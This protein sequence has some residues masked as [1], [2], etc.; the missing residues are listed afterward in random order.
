MLLHQVLVEDAPSPRK[1]NGSVPKDLETIC[2]KCL[3][4]D[5][6]R[7]YQT[8]RQ[9]G[10][11]LQRFHSGEPV[12]ARPISRAERVWRWCRRKPGMAAALASIAALLVLVTLISSVA[13]VYLR[14]QERKQRRLADSNRELAEQAQSAERQAEDESERN[15]RLLYTSDM[16]LAL[17]AWE[18]A[19][20]NRCLELLD[21]H[22]PPPGKEDLRGFEWNYVAQLCQRSQHATTLDCSTDVFGVAF[23]PDDKTLATAHNNTLSLWQLNSTDPPVGLPAPWNGATSVSYSPDGKLLA[24]GNGRGT[25]AIWDVQGERQLHTLK[26]NSTMCSAVA[27][28]PDGN[29]LASANRGRGPDNV[30]L[31]DVTTGQLLVTL[32]SHTSPVSD[33]MDVAF[34]PD[35]KV[36]ASAGY[37]ATLRVWDA[38]THEE[39][40]VLDGHNERV[41][42]VAF[43]PDGKVLASGGSDQNIRLWDTSTWQ[44]VALLAGHNQTVTSVQFS[45]DGETLASG[46]FDRE[47]KLWNLNTNK[48]R[49]TL[50]GHSSVVSSLA[51][52]HD[53]TTLASASH[54][55]TVKIWD[56]APDK[57]VHL[58]EGT[59]A[60]G[61]ALS[62]YADVSADGS[63]I[64]SE[65]FGNQIRVHDVTTGK[66]W[67]LP[68]EGRLNVAISRGGKLLALA[69]GTDNTIRVRDVPTGAIVHT[70]ANPADTFPLSF[71]G[72]GKLLAAGC[73]DG[74]IT[75]WNMET[76]ERRATLKGSQAVPVR[77]FAFSP[78]DRLLASVHSD[79]QIKLRNIATGQLRAKLWGAAFNLTFSPDGRTLVSFGKEIFVSN[80]ATGQRIELLEGHAG[81]VTSLAFS[82]NGKWLAS[83]SEDRNVILWDTTNWEQRFVFKG[84]EHGVQ[85]VAFTPDG[86]CLA[87]AEGTGTIRLWRATTDADF[88]RKAI[89]RTNLV[90]RAYYRGVKGEY[91]QAADDARRAEQLSPEGSSTR[92]EAAYYLAFLLLQL[93]KVQEY[94]Q[95]CLRTLQDFQD[96]ENVFIACQTAALC[97][98]HPWHGLGHERAAELADVAA[99]NIKTAIA[100]GSASSDLVPLVQLVKGICDYRRGQFAAAID[101]LERDELSEI[102]VPHFKALRLLFLAMAYHH[103]GQP[104][105]ARRLFQHAAEMIGELPTQG[106]GWQYVTFCRIARH[107]SEK[108]IG[109]ECEDNRPNETVSPKEID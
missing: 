7:R 105:P 22:R 55:G 50:K 101:W 37:D 54:D 94:D 92:N 20:L 70:L 60:P 40:V 107:E 33:V 26:V 30:K 31:W 59:A 21:R 89:T 88:Q 85:A 66:E 48:E 13:A 84:H 5:P 81:Y 82:P 6:H 77:D 75:L 56:V 90:A 24:V 44:E 103:D 39:L 35:G 15:R 104:V 12:E 28:S 64:A 93:G 57:Q 32:A 79:G 42:A 1:L 41:W 52:S 2:L 97:A 58:I 11:D 47:I 43:S 99:S 100:E 95:L 25:L 65:S 45:P 38:T 106:P 23:S 72:D 74:T 46:C 87:S 10:E 76:G 16:R 36:L 34:S 73:R 86:K 83:G 68:E 8:A 91:V 62:F 63:T 108:L 14:S 9:L 98:I 4:K 67:F 3:E 96:T 102:E 29:I 109:V 78:D 49:E 53:G 61:D 69:T 51:Y 19:N 71:S 18:E 17:N 27:F 80:V